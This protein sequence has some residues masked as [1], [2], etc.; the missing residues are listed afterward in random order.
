M[1][2]FT[3]QPDAA[4]RTLRELVA[5]VKAVSATAMRGVNS[6]DCFTDPVV[7]DLRLEELQEKARA[8]EALL[9]VLELNRQALRGLRR[10]D[11]P[12]PEE[13]RLERDPPLVRGAR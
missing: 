7:D 1:A 6:M 13:V 3:C 8:A 9:D 4:E 2:R 12:D 5:A 11:M 10:E